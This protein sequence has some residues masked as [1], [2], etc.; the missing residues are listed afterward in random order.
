ME[1][2]PSQFCSLF[3]SVEPLGPTSKISHLTFESFGWQNHQYTPQGHGKGHERS[4]SFSTMSSGHLP[5]LI[6]NVIILLLK[7]SHCVFHMACLRQNGW[8]REKQLSQQRYL[9]DALPERR[10]MTMHHEISARSSLMPAGDGFRYPVPDKAVRE[11]KVG[12]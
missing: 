5:A 10:T 8:K 1:V 9:L 6:S 7:C 4:V 11:G 3:I 2:P 12:P